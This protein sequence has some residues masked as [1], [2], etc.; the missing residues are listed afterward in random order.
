MSE[1]VLCTIVEGELLLRAERIN[2]S[3]VPS[4][5]ERGNAGIAEAKAQTNA[6]VDCAE[7]AVTRYSAYKE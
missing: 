4:D 6:E 5:D 3:D 2:C 1:S 7:V